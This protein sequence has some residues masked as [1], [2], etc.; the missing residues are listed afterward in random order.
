MDTAL[1]SCTHH[2]QKNQKHKTRVCCL[3]NSKWSAYQYSKLSDSQIPLIA[4]CHL[5]L[6][7]SSAVWRGTSPV[8]SFI[9]SCLQ[10]IIWLFC[11]FLSKIFKMIWQILIVI[12]KKLFCYDTQK[13][14]LPE[15][16]FSLLS[17][18]LL[19]NINR[20][21]YHLYLLFHSC[22]HGSSQPTCYM[23]YLMSYCFPIPPPMP[24]LMVGS[25]IQVW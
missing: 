20:L 3:S 15:K 6:D 9:P 22:K 1:H 4:T 8:T 25:Y 11:L 13:M 18:I 5:E 17:C 7:S 16:L 10:W 19:Y 2:L 14:Y 21:C 12:W 23:L 24:P